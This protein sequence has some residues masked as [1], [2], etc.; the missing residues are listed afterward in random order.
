MDTLEPNLAPKRHE[1]SWAIAAVD[2]P[3][4]DPFKRNARIFHSEQPTGSVVDAAVYATNHFG[5]FT[6]E[7]SH[8][9]LEPHPAV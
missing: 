5:R 9:L 6:A 3:A 4:N 1:F 8:L 2:T 7:S